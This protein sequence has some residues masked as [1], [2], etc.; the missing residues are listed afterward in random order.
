MDVGKQIA[1]RRTALGM[2]QAD[3]A[4]A[5]EITV[6]TIGSVERDETWP[7]KKTLTAIE[8]ALGWAPGSL[9]QIRDGGDPTPLD[10]T[11]GDGGADT[12]H[13]VGIPDP[14]KVGDGE[15]IDTR[16]GQDLTS[17]RASM[18]VLDSLPS[19]VQDLVMQQARHDPFA[20]G[21]LLTPENDRR[22]IRFAFELLDEQDAE[23][24]SRRDGGSVPD[25]V[26]GE[27]R[28]EF[29][30]DAMSDEQ[31]A[32]LGATDEVWGGY[33]ESK[34]SAARPEGGQ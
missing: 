25:G 32:E 14:A 5:A 4:Q 10:T 18:R 30:T 20:V 21:G 9:E 22:L 2:T 23:D 29:H 28:R 1:Q 6:R 3:L 15:F 8:R 26:G 11:S 13:H 31:L 19:P 24:T 16:Q 33:V 7:R 12:P 17:L 34:K 27:T